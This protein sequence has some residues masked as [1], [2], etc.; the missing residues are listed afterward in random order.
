[1]LR[2]RSVF[3]FVSISLTLLVSTYFAAA[4]YADRS[5]EYIDRSQIH[6]CG[7]WERGR[8][9][10]FLGILHSDLVCSVGFIT[11]ER[12]DPK[13]LSTCTEFPPHRGFVLKGIRSTPE[14]YHWIDL[15]F[16]IHRYIL[17]FLKGV[18]TLRPLNT[19]LPPNP[20]FFV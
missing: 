2:Y 12:P 13:D 9:V 10:S 14:W 19:K 16:V 6:E 8:A 17:G 5:W 18:K 3:A 15:G 7:N 11:V 20:K 1:M 4:K